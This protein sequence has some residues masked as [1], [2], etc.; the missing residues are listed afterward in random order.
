MIILASVLQKS[1]VIFLLCPEA[2]DRA[3]LEECG[4]V[5]LDRTP[6]A[7]LIRIFGTAGEFV[8]LRICL[9]FFFSV[10]PFSFLDVLCHS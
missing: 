6:R 8:R 10:V 7:F 1:F 5:L 3:A 4:H 9:S 2:L